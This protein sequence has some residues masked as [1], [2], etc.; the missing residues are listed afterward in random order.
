MGKG[1]RQQEIRRRRHRRKK[2]AKLRRK[3]LLKADGAAKTA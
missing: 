3:G 2:R 1:T